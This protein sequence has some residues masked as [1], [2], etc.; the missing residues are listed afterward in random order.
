MQ[1]VKQK[2]IWYENVYDFFVECIILW[3]WHMETV[4]LWNI[5][6]YSHQ[7]KTMQQKQNEKF[8]LVETKMQ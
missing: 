3:V 5:Y 7:N 2:N 6:K 4:M 1:M 8:T